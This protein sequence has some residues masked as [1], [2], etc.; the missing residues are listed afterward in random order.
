MRLSRSAV[1]LAG[2][3][4]FAT[5][6]ARDYDKPASRA[7]QQA[8]AAV[9]VFIDADWG[10]REDGAARELTDAHAAFARHG[11]DV[12]D[13]VAYT[14]NGDLEGFFVTYRRR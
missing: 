13:V 11:Y 12:V 4:A 7:Q 1:L 14:E 8:L 10:G 6:T 9:T 2:V 5:A 3:L